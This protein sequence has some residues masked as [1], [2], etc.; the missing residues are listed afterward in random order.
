MAVEISTHF[1]L[2]YSYNLF[3]SMGEE[4]LGDVIAVIFLAYG[5]FLLCGCIIVVVIMRRLSVPLLSW[6]MVWTIC[7]TPL[8]MHYALSHWVDVETFPYVFFAGVTLLAGME[9][10]R[11]LCHDLSHC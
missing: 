5:V 10:Q 6:R 7:I 1:K 2:D 4:H 3:D 11:S 8:T 9:F